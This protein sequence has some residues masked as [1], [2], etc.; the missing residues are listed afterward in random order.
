[1]LDGRAAILA[2][3]RSGGFPLAR[4]LSVPFFIALGPAVPAACVLSWRVPASPLKDDSS[5]ATLAKKALCS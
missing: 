1:M 3:A 2:I 5:T 4:F